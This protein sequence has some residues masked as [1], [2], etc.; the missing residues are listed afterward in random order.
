M[1]VAVM[2]F[3][4][5]VTAEITWTVI[6]PGEPH[7]YEI[8][9]EHSGRAYRRLRYRMEVLETLRMIRRLPENDA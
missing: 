1:R 7:L 5:Y 4:C 3:N 9:Q 2:A 6:K 8:A